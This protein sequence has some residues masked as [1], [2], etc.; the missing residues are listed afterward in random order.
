MLTLQP[1]TQQATLLQ[2]LLNN[3]KFNKN[4]ETSLWKEKKNTL[5]QSRRKLAY[6]NRIFSLHQQQKHQKLE[7]R[8]KKNNLILSYTGIPSFFPAQTKTELSSI[9]RAQDDKEQYITDLDKVWNKAVSF[10]L[11]R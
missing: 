7:W 11:L 2:P 9:M 6:N 5:S 1:L 8:G 4:T 3:G 10:V